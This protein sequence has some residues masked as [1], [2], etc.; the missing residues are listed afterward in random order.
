[1]ASHCSVFS[2]RRSA[3]NIR[4]LV[5]KLPVRLRGSGLPL[6]FSMIPPGQTLGV[7]GGGALGRMFA[8]A[9]QPLGYRVHVFEP[10][11]GCPAGAVANEEINA[12]CD[13]R[14]ALRAFAHDC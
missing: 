6:D 4:R 14:A 7:L 10:Q 9:A 12:S 5:A 13:N 2:V 3:F 11:A 1:M 8:Q